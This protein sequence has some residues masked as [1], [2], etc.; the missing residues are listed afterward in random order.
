MR[1]AL[2]LVADI[3]TLHT[4]ARGVVCPEVWD[5]LDE[6]KRRAQ[7]E[8]EEVAFDLPITSSGFLIR[9]HGWRGYAYW[10]S[11]PDFELMLGRSEKFPAVVCQLHA[12]YLHS[13]GVGWA[14]EFVEL[15]AAA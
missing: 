1:L 8:E 14:L 9:P 4:S 12:A 10:L 7:G 15:V 6:A 5:L 11:S 13:V 3:D 2:L